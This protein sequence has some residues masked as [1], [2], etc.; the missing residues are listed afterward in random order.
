M[1]RIKVHSPSGDDNREIFLPLE[2]E[3]GLHNPNVA[4]ETPVPGVIVFRLEESYTYP[5]ASLINSSLVDH[6]KVHTRRGR[7]IALVR[8]IDRPWNEPGPRRGAAFDPAA[9]DTSKPLLRAVVLDF[10]AVYVPSTSH[11]LAFMLFAHLL[12][13]Y[14][15]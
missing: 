6:A 7:D 10:A 12:I 1:G 8:L 11:T 5:N 9:H 4:I 2:K 14:F 15:L 13:F 3:G